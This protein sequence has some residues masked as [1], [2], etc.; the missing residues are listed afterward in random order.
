M[1]Q[2]SNHAV[3]D[4]AK[5]V[6]TSKQEPLGRDEMEVLCKISLMEHKL[7]ADESLKDDLEKGKVG[8][9][10]VFWHRAKA[11]GIEVP[12]S[13][14]LVVGDCSRNFGVITM[15][16]AYLKWWCYANGKTSVSLQDWGMRIFPMGYLSDKTWQHLWDEQKCFDGNTPLS[17]LL[18]DKTCYE[19]IMK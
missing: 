7:N 3:E 12:P 15:L 2:K 1:I 8:L 11:L 14:A 5:L 10:S 4:W 19:S 13:L 17:N 18:D 6:K 9:A 16:A